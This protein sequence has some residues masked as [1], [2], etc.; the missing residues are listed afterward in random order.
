MKV[1]VTGT[2]HRLRR[3]LAVRAAA[4]LIVA[5]C[6]AAHAGEKLTVG[7]VENV[8]IFP[9]GLS[10][11]AKIDSG[12]DHSSVNAKAVEKFVRDGSDWVR[13]SLTNDLGRTIVVERPVLR[14]ARIRRH[15]GLIEE[16][17]VLLLG[18]CLGNIFKQIEV[19]IVDRSGLAYPVLIGRSYLKGAFLVDPGARFMHEPRCPSAA[20][21]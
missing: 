4:C 5:A 7:Y 2:V 1:M 15:G 6:S 11:Q 3:A 14:T 12:A 9:G 21:E 19:N 8:Q 13:F 17:D 10:L 16:R 18:I 20:R